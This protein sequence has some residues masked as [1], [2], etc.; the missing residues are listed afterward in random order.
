MV[1]A[2]STGDRGTIISDFRFQIWRERFWRGRANAEFPATFVEL[3]SYL[4]GGKFKFRLPSDT[5]VENTPW[6]RIISHACRRRSPS[7]WL[8]SNLQPN[9]MPRDHSSNISL[10]RFFSFFINWYGLR[11]DYDC[12]QSAYPPAFGQ[13]ITRFSWAIG[14]GRKVKFVRWIRHVLLVRSRYDPRCRLR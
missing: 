1:W 12:V 9:S 4:F 6:R 7:L 2:S 8:S 13:H 14:C 10:L 3:Y 5:S 11:I